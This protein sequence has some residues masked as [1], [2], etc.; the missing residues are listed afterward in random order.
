MDIKVSIDGKLYDNINDIAKFSDKEQIMVVGGKTIGNIVYINRNTLK[1]FLEKD[2]VSQDCESA[3]IDQGLL[4][5]SLY[6]IA[7]AGNDTVFM[8]HTHPCKTIL[9]DFFYGSLSEEDL[10]NS[11]NLC[12]WGKSHNFRYLDGIS[13]GKDTYFWSVDNDEFLPSQVYSYVDGTLLNN[14]IPAKIDNLIN[15]FKHFR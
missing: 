7:R 13:T 4:L 3:S 12:L 5:K 14:K 8:I 10:K 2:L 6:N 15:K 11:K 1:W 9:D